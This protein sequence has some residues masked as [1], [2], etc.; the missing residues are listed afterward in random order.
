MRS[1]IGKSHYSDDSLLPSSYGF[2]VGWV[3]ETPN[4]NTINKKG[5][6]KEIVKH[7]KYININIVP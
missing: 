3:R 2:E 7:N 5:V 4:L 1:R 6:N